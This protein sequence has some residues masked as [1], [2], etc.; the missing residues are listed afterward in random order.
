MVDVGDKPVTDREAVARGSIAMSAEARKLIRSGAVKKGDPIQAAR[1][2]GIMAAKKTSELI[3]LCH[4]LN[5]SHVSVDLTATRAGYAIEARVRISGQTGVEMEA[6]TAVSVAALTLYDMVKAVDKTMVIGDIELVE[7]KGGTSVISGNE[8][9]DLHSAAG[10]QWQIPVEGVGRCAIDFPIQFIH[11]TTPEQRAGGLHDCDAAYTW[12]LNAAELAQAAKLR[13]VHT[14]AVAV[15]TL[16]LPELFARGVAVSNTRG[17]QAVPIAEHVMAVMLALAKQLP[18]VIENQQQARWA[19]NEFMGERLPWLLKGRTLGWSAS[20]RSA[21]D[22][23]A[24]RSV[25]HAG[26]RLAPASRLRRDRPRRAG[27]RADQ[28]EE[29]LGQSYVLVIPAP[30]TPETLADW[31]RAVRAA[32]KGRDRRQRRPRQDHRHRRADRGTAL[33]SPRRRVAR[34]VPAGAAAAGSSAMEDPERHPHPA[35]LRISP[36][37][38][39]RGR[40]AVRR[41]HRTILDRAATEIPNRAGARILTNSD[42][43]GRN[44]KWSSYS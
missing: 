41:Q 16:C 26:D 3:P 43:K 31:R 15:E 35:H 38:L 39:G 6:L 24:R 40:A 7:K 8:D 25:R 1:L 17:V 36:R 34:R 22:R 13:W 2:A 10:Q 23:E 12:I 33:G 18:F 5:L 4:P 11:A 21:R 44:S 20:A 27:L 19:Q 42:L 32:A 28:L 29:F 14:S 37:T 30:L 9:P